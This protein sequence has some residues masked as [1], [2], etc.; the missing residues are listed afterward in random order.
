MNSLYT[1]FIFLVLASLIV[2][3]IKLIQRLIAYIRDNYSLREIAVV[4]NSYE[5]SADSSQIGFELAYTGDTPLII[6]KVSVQSR[7]AREGWLGLISWLQLIPALIRSDEYGLKTV[8]GD[9][10]PYYTMLWLIPIHKIKNIPIRF[11]VSWISA[12]YH[13]VLFIYW[14]WFSVFIVLFPIPILFALLLK[15]WF[16]SP[17]REFNLETNESTLKLFDC[18]ESS[19]SMIQ[20]SGPTSGTCPIVVKFPRTGFTCTDIYGSWEG[21]CTGYHFAS[22]TLT[23]NPYKIENP[24]KLPGKGKFIF[25]AEHKLILSIK[26]KS[27]KLIIKVPKGIG[28]RFVY[29]N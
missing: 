27:R 23:E 1:V 6:D 2:E 18:N 26:E 16:P 24:W 7:L 13:I 20:F 21:L 28:P 25:L 22:D 17:Y 5:Q 14:I 12:I 3:M 15:F 29:I 4:V 10:Y 19:I 11:I 9:K 8:I